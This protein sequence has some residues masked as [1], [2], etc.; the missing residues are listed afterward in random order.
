MFKPA[1]AALVLPFLLSVAAEAR[2]PDIEAAI[3]AARSAIDQPGF[4]GSVMV[5]VDG[6]PRIA[7]I[8]G[9]ADQEAGR[10]NTPETRFNIAS[11]GK[12]LTAT[13]Y[14]GLADELAD[15]GPDFRERQ[16]RSLLPEHAEMFGAALTA[17][18]LMAHR[19]QVQGLMEA[20]QSETR[21][22]EASSNADLFQLVA[23][24]QSGPVDRRY[25]GLAYNNA[26]AIILGEIVASLSGGTYEA[27]IRNR[28]LA[29]VGAEGALFTRLAAAE[30]EQLAWPYVEAGFDPEVH[31]RPGARS[32]G[33]LPQTYPIRAA[34]PLTG[35]VSSAAGGLYMTAGELAAVGAG[36]LDGRLLHADQLARMCESVLPIPGRTLGS[37]C[38][39]RELSPGLNRWGHSGGAAG[40]NAQLAL[41]PELGLV[42]VVLSNHH[43]RADPVMQAFETAL[44]PQTPDG[45]LPGGF[46]IRH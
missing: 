8:R 39:G 27:A 14:V 40:V 24:V 23:E 38:A 1:L 19:S 11:V 10:L 5:L 30:A 26:N 21:M 3:E 44:T 15:G 4:S 20:P 2:Q 45:E 32:A 16:V 7:E 43:G 13:A 12:F 37:G 17:G 41:Y 35:S 34:T 33:A 31:M 28:V 42:L 36:V 46:T 25:D 6:E 18:D 29:P 22:L 9:F